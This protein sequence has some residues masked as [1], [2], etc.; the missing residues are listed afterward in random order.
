MFMALFQVLMLSLK[1]EM[2]DPLEE[3]L[4]THSSTLAEIIPWTE[5]L[6]GPEPME[7]QRVRHN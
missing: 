6:G 3:E 7:W 2:G 1:T 5:D 4:A